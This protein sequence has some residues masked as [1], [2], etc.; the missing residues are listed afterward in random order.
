MLPEQIPVMS[1]LCWSKDRQHKESIFI[2][3]SI[4][5][6]EQQL[7]QDDNIDHEDAY[8]DRRLFFHAFICLC[9]QLLTG[10][11]GERSHMSHIT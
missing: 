9:Q 6:N 5:F 1:M 2:I 10:A 3:K 11:T 4:K 7:V 8:K